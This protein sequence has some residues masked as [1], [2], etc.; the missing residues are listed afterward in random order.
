[1]RRTSVFA[2][3]LAFLGLCAYI[4]VAAP[5]PFVGSVGRPITHS[6]QPPSYAVPQ[7]PVWHSALT[8]I[9][10]LL[11]AIRTLNPQKYIAVEQWI[12]TQQ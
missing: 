7:R 5:I 10:A 9:V 12:H 3:A 4:S 2:L 11:I 1:M 6:Y 8:G